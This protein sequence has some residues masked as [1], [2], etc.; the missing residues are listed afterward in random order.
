MHE[1]S[2]SIFH[3]IK[4][5]R[6]A[7]RYLIG[8]G[9]DIGAG[10]D[11]IAQYHEFF[12]LMRSCRAWDKPDGDAELMAS[13]ADNTFDFVH[14]SHCLEHMRNVENAL[15]NWLRILKPGGHLICII[16]DEDLYEQGVFPSKF[17]YD[18][19]HTFTIYKQSSPIKVS[20]N[21]IE[22]LSQLSI[23]VQIK[24]IELLDATYR[25]ELARQ[26]RAN[27]QITDQTQT[28]IGECAIEFILQK[29]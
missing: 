10:P 14:S 1:S 2:K 15:S 18:H 20:I 13:I 17:N 24:K 8:D 7:T 11:C 16:P 3:K 6:Y 26:L 27:K 28:P 25:Y 5:S 19:K 23:P 9:I 21:L 22:L 12:P 29:L 4:D